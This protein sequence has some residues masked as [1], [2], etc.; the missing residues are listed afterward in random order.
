VLD[1]HRYA[2]IPPAVLQIE[3]HP[4][5]V[6]QPLLDLA[7]S[8]DMAVTAYCSFGPASWVELDM[9]LEVPSLLQHDTI[10]SIASKHG[11]SAIFSVNPFIVLLTFMQAQPKFYFDGLLSEASP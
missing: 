2:R 7:K 9:H 10:G 4:Y 1:L 8:L 6:Q 5:L 3:H 11:K